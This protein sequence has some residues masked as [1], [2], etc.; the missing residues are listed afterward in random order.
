MS[1]HRTLD[2]IFR[3]PAPAAPIHD[4]RGWWR[5]HCDATR[6]FS[7]P[8][9]LAVVTGFLSDR[10]GYAFASGYQ[11]A[12][13]AAWPN[14]DPQRVAALCVSEA[15]GNG[16][17]DMQTQIQLRGDTVIVSGEK[18]FATLGTF[19]QEL[20]VVGR[21]GEV[22]GRPRLGI[23]LVDSDASGAQLTPHKALSFAPEIPHAHLQLDV[24]VPA[25]RLSPDDGWDH[26]VKP[27]G[28]MEDALVRA[29]I[30]GHLVG[31]ARYRSWPVEELD[32]LGAAAT[33]LAAFDVA[34]DL[35]SAAVWRVL[36]AT[37]V[38]ADTTI[39]QA[40]Q[41]LTKAAADDLNDEVAQR[42]VRDR[43]LMFLARGRRA[44]RLSRARRN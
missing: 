40:D 36:E 17:R 16:P 39:A 25:H 43:P 28:A 10:L 13:H 7:S 44:A 41:R 26:L 8:G 12:V 18:S 23:V 19:A 33:A 42:W 30:C 29:A 35:R 27:F 14:L 1:L 9:A 32:A 34:T 5:R 6:S 3:Q 31:V 4:L 20:L 21:V 37:L 2:F 22:A 24:R 15:N 11:S 38:Y